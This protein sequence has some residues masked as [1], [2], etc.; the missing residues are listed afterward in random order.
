M[1]NL[2]LI[3]TVW[4]VGQIIFIVAVCLIVIVIVV[5]F[6][7]TIKLCI[8]LCGM[9]NTL[10]LSP[11]VYMY[12]RGRQLYKFYNEEVRPPVLE[13]DDIV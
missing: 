2:F 11:S 12:Y 1:I 6:L 13:V 10:I 4:Y 7:A 3:D 9:C 8:Q 5:A